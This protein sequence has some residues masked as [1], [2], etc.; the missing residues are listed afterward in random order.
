M[1]IDGSERAPR[2]ANGPLG[3]P[4]PLGR[5]L[6]MHDATARRRVLM[7][8]LGVSLLAII[9]VSTAS[10]LESTTFWLEGGRVF[11]PD[12]TRTLGQALA[13]RGISVINGPRG[14]LG[15]PAE[16]APEAIK[17]IDRKGLTRRSLAELIDQPIQPSPFADPQEREQIRRR[18]RERRAEAVL[19]RFSGVLDATV[20]LSE[21]RPRRFGQPAELRATVFLSPTEPGALS[22]DLIGRVETT[23]I[24]L[25]PDLVRG[26]DLTVLDDAGRSYLEAG[27]PTVALRTRADARALEWEKALSRRLA[28]VIQGIRISV[29]MEWPESPSDILRAVPPGAPPVPEGLAVVPNAPVVLADSPAESNAPTTPSD[30]GRGLAD[31]LVEIPSQYFLDRYRSVAG[32]ERI[33]TQAELQ[34]FVEQASDLIEKAVRHEIPEPNLGHFRIAKLPLPSVRPAAP[35]TR[36]RPAIDPRMGWAGALGAGA[37]VLILVATAGTRRLAKGRRSAQTGGPMRTRFD[38]EDQTGPADRVRELVRRDPEAAAG[39]LRRWVGQG[40]PTE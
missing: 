2:E 7:A 36:S 5:L 34:P 20:L 32:A 13:E 21:A 27:D 6:A 4:R 8:V 14:Q 31:V 9:L 24:A 29:R 12:E 22:A 17:L 23:L 33:P 35:T 3:L 39:V 10:Q 37:L 16:S 15:V 11:T 18:N 1:R 28:P 38:Q 30:A 40:G 19:E 26:R 25:E